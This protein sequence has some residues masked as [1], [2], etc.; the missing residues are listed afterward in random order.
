MS[1]GEGRTI[2]V[3][4]EAVFGDNPSGEMSQDSILTFELELLSAEDN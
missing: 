3:T 1:I 4:Y 2:I